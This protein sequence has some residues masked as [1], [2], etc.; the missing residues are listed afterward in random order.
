M[1]HLLLA[2]MDVLGCAEIGI[3]EA[4]DVVDWELV[5]PDVSL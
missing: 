4:T 3:V 2:V 5:M 1:T